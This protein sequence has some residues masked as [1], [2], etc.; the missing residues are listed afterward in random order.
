[1]VVPHGIYPLTSWQRLEHEPRLAVMSSAAVHIRICIFVQNNVIFLSGLYPGVELFAGSCA[2]LCL[3]FQG[4]ARLFSPMAAPFRAPAGCAGGF[5][6]LRFLS[7]TALVMASLSFCFLVSH[8]HR[9]EVRSHCGF[10]LHF[11][12]G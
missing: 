5:P 4:P 10:D 8:P 1:M 3:T 7:R 12:G 11:S 6:S 9:G 2:T